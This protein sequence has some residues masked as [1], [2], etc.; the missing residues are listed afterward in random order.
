[1]GKDVLWM[2]DMRF[3]GYDGHQFLVLAPMGFGDG[4]VRI[5]NR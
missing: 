2:K 1:M 5:G 4:F 3:K